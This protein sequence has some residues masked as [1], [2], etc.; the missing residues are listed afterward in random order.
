MRSPSLF[1]DLFSGLGGAS[2]AFVNDPAWRVLRIDNNPALLE[3]APDTVMCDLTDTAATLRIIDDWLTEMVARHGPMKRLVVWASPPCYEFSTAFSAPRPSA[4]RAGL[5]FTPSMAC[6]EATKTLIAELMPE[7]W[8]VE[9][10]RGAVHDFEPYFGRWRQHHGPFYLW[11]K[12]P[13]VAL[14]D[15]P[16]HRK[17]EVGTAYRHAPK[18]LRQ[19][20]RAEVPFEVSERV[21][22]AL[23]R[24]TT[25][26]DW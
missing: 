21:T 11:G 1:V 12:F 5:E 23:E 17:S 4:H 7:A 26:S 8:F 24:Q 6:V 10:V 15:L 18:W 9:N 2:S 25:L 3:F 22:E 20:K 13:N 19:N 16:V 14:S